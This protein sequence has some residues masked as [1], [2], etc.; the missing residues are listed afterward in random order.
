MDRYDSIMAIRQ[1]R[2]T[3]EYLWYR[4]LPESTM[5]QIAGNGVSR[6][7]SMGLTPDTL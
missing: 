7:D 1:V 5:L 4:F 2:V 6:D 3:A